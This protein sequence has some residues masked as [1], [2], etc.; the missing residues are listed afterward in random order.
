MKH[1]VQPVNIPC[2]V[3]S[4]IRKQQL[5]TLRKVAAVN[6]LKKLGGGKAAVG[7]IREGGSGNGR[8]DPALNVFDGILRLQKRGSIALRCK[9]ALVADENIRK[10]CRV[11]A[12]GDFIVLP[13]RRKKCADFRNRNGNACF[14]PLPKLGKNA[15]AGFVFAS[16]IRLPQNHFAKKSLNRKIGAFLAKEGVSFQK[17]KGFVTDHFSSGV[18]GGGCSRSKH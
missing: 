14:K 12:E 6:G 5:G 18:I 13:K 16:A 9:I 4:G 15:A 11:R 2:R 3:K 17:G 8:H 10:S 7:F 1:V